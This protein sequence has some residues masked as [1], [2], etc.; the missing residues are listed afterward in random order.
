VNDEPADKR[1]L[2][3]YVVPPG[4]VH[5]VW[6]AVQDGVRK[7]LL[8]ASEGWTE[9]VVR[10]C[11]NDGTLTLMLCFRGDDE[12]VGHLVFSLRQ[13]PDGIDFNCFSLEGNG[14]TEAFPMVL[15]YARELG[16]VSMSFT[17]KRRGFERNKLGFEPD[18]VFYRREL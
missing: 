7:T 17:T 13:I 5:A 12:V 11:L 1:E 15:D 9:E 10:Q 16:A 18:R 14:I 6:W 8:Q 4:M 3:V 2:S